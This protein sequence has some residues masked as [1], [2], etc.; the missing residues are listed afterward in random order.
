MLHILLLILKII[1]IIIAVLLGIVL[2][3]LLILLF[4]PV[5]YEAQGI[6]KGSSDSLKGKVK[7]TWLLN[8]L[9]VDVMYKEKHMTWRIRLLFWKRSSSK[10]KKA[11]HPEEGSYE[12]QEIKEEKADEEKTPIT[13]DAN[14]TDEPEVKEPEIKEA[15]VADEDAKSTPEASEVLQTEKNQERHSEDKTDPSKAEKKKSA[16][17]HKNKAK[18]F[19][20]KIKDKKEQVTS[21]IRNETHKEA[22]EKVKKELFRLLKILRPKR[23][24]GNIIFGFEDPSY[25]GKTLAL[26]SVF[27]PFFGPVFTITPDFEQAI[28]KGNLFCKGKIR[29]SYFVH[30]VWV[31]FWNRNVRATY[32]D[33]KSINEK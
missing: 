15:A 4:V 14:N 9:R 10:G 11:V 16:R 25:T 27:Y 26:L 13:D 1:G 2:A 8:L 20:R 28:F 29:L 5:R 31:L 22:F 24:E 12:K 33:I 6:C 21:F 19:F 23:L 3:L 7:L 17:K 32:R 30:P 18:D